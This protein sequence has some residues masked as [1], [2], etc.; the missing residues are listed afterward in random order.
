MIRNKQKKTCL[1]GICLL[2]LACLSIS[3]AASPAEQKDDVYRLE[4]KD[5]SVVIGSRTPEQLPFI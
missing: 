1:A 4:D 2:M 5:M 3:Y